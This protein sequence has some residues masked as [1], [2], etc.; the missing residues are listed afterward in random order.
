MKRNGMCPVCYLKQFFTP[1]SSVTLTCDFKRVL[2]DAPSAPIMGWSSWNTFRNEIDE[3]LIL[4]TAKALKET[5][6]LDAGYR[7]VNLDDN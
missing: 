3:K 6:L 2:P 4:D 1:R 5:G 7:Y